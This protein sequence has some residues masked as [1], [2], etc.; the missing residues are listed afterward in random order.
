MRHSERAPKMV[1]FM[2]YINLLISIIF[3]FLI[4][5]KNSELDKFRWDEYE[6]MDLTEYGIWVTR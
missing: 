2:K 4:V 5:N 1:E 3:N 6:P